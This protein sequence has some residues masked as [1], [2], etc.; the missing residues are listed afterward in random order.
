MKILLINAPMDIKKPAFD[1][2][3]IGSAYIAS[4]LVEDGH[5]VHVK[6]FEAETY[7]PNSFIQF[8]EEFSPKLIGLSSTTPSFPATKLLIDD[9]RQNYSEFADTFIVL[10]GHHATGLPERSLEETGA[11]IVVRG[12]GE[13]TVVELARVLEDGDVKSLKDVKGITYQSNGEMFHC[14]NRELIEDLDS[15]PFPARDLLPMEMYRGEIGNLASDGKFGSI[16]SSRGCPFSCIFCYNSKTKKG[17]RKIRFR[18]AKNV[19]DEIKILKERYNRNYIYFVDDHLTANRPRLHDL[20]NLLKETD[21]KWFCQSR[22]DAVDYN[23]LKEMKEAGCISI[24]YGIET[25]DLNTLKYIN[26]RT[27]LDQARKA[28]KDTKELGIETRPSFMIGFPI[29]TKQSILQTIRF[30]KELDGD[31]TAFFVVVPFPHSKLWDIAIDEGY[32]NEHNIRWEMFTQY[33]P[34]FATK[35]ISKEDLIYWLEFARTFVE[36]ERI[37][38]EA[39]SIKNW[40]TFLHK[41]ISHRG[42][43][44]PHSFYLSSPAL[45][46]FIFDFLKALAG[47]ANISRLRFIKSQVHALTYRDVTSR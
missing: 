45:A 39:I 19:F 34:I 10:G 21:I 1:K 28:I 26:K 11:D 32:I 24:G 33:D 17:E 31:A 12:E 18:S 9:L 41:I 42:R 13:R 43:E 25:G 44:L 7:E 46:S 35:D 3:A 6:D 23:M 29:D 22:V 37:K 14:P 15:I 40:R 2:E 30:A 4:V 38:S 27:T 16:V 20:C 5:D 36:K 47:K 8:C